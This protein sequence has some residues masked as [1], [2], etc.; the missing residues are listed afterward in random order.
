MIKKKI[1]H[2]ELL[3]I[4]EPGLTSEELD[5]RASR[6]VSSITHTHTHKARDVQHSTQ[7]RDPKRQQWHQRSFCRGQREQRSLVSKKHNWKE[8]ELPNSN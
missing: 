2:A 5:R 3:T 7:E 1:I 6:K 4:N 8:Y